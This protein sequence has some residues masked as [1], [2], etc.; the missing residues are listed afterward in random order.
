MKSKDHVRVGIFV[1]CSF[2][3]FLGLVFGA[4]GAQLGNREAHYTV[5][6]DETVKGMVVG[7][8]V[9]FQGVRIGRVVDMRFVSGRTEVLIAVD[10]AKAPIQDNTVASLDRAW[11]TGQVTVELTGWKA[12][13]MLLAEYGIIEAELSPGARVMR[14]MPEV[15]TRATEILEDFGGV[16]HRVREILAEDSPWMRES[17]G[18]VRDARTA[19]RALTERSMP[20]ADAAIADLREILPRVAEA[21]DAWQSVG[22]S[23]D[24]VLKD[25][26]MRGTV[27]NAADALRVLRDRLPDF[28]RV[29]REVEVFFRGN[30]GELRSVLSSLSTAMRE[31]SDVA[32]VMQKA[33]N[34]LLFGY[35]KNERE[36][37][38]E[39]LQVPAAPTGGR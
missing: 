16:A 34:A 36:T 25:P 37:P 9:N 3:L 30:R 19:L 22:K 27:A 11:V 35:R 14:T 18:L 26:A 2:V 29:A 24:A 13:G 5:H 8:P 17:L 15:A 39:R 12:E 4:I 28:A 1:V 32:R 10:P 38:R 23:A 21:A 33:P 6:F 31:I 7:S 20:G